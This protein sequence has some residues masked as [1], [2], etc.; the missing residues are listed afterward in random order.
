M[1][2]C[3]VKFGTDETT[4]KKTGPRKVSPLSRVTVESDSY[5]VSL[6]SKIPCFAWIDVN[7]D[8]QADWFSVISVRS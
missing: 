6:A 2:Y 4:E 1:L 3:L 7:S 5:V 8:W